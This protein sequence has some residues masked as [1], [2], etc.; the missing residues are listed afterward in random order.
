IPERYFIVFD[1]PSKE[2]RGEHAHRVCK[3]FLVCL[4]GSVSVVCDDGTNRQEFVLDS[5][6]LG[7]YVPPMV[8]CIQ[9]KYTADALLLVLASHPDD[10]ADYIRNYAEFLAAKGGGTQP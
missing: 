8:W 6:E 5:P 10:S 7:L 1:V 9:Y 3:Q 2:V 4:K